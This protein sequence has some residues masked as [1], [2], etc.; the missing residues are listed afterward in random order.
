MALAFALALDFASLFD[1]F[2]SASCILA[3]LALA[4]STIFSHLLHVSAVTKSRMLPTMWA[5]G[6]SCCFST[7]WQLDSKSQL[8]KNVGARGK[9]TSK[10]DLSHASAVVPLSQQCERLER[11]LSS[12]QTTVEREKGQVINVVAKLSE[13]H[14]TN[15]TFVVQTRLALCVCE[16]R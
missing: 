10:A 11:Q 12:T 1:S 7:V 9:G 13:W 14:F 2:F 8:S 15:V 3:I 4:V 5:G 16:V 6:C